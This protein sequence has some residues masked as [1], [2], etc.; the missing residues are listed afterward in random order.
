MDDEPKTQTD[1][2]PAAPAPAVAPPAVDIEAIVA[3]RLAVAQAQ[4]AAEAEAAR[5]AALA[6]QGQ[7]QQLAEERARR[8]AELE[9]EAQAA[10]RYRAALEAQLTASKKDLPPHITA[11][12]DKMDPADQLEYLAANADALRPTVAA[13]NINARTAQA[14]QPDPAVREAELRARYRI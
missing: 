6:E 2:P 14:A 5:Q 12:L 1:T 13:P 4:Q 11:L 7:H 3:Q 9:P 8:I 10:A